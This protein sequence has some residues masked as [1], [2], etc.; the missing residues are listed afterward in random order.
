VLSKALSTELQSKLLFILFG[1]SLA[2][3]F[4]LI[5]FNVLIHFFST[6]SATV[7]GAPPT[8]AA[9]AATLRA[10]KEESKLLSAILE[11]VR[12]KEIEAER[13]LEQKKL[14]AKEVIAAAEP[15]VQTNLA[16]ADPY[17]SAWSHRGPPTGGGAGGS[18]PAH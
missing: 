7:K 8:K 13:T 1:Y 17:V 5:K 4:F 11:D 10:K 3:A 18:R 14:A 6:S 15:V 9:R 2:F 12:K 16:D